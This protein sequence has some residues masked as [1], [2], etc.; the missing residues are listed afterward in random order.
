MLRDAKLKHLSE[1]ELK[2]FDDSVRIF[3]SKKYVQLETESLYDEDEE[4]GH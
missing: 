1:S 4:D 2:S 3:L